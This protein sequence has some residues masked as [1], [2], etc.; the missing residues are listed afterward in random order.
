MAVGIDN[1]AYLTMPGISSYHCQPER[2]I[3]TLTQ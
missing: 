2:E 3:A 1:E